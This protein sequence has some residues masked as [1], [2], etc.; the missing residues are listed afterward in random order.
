[1]VDTAVRRMSIGWTLLVQLCVV[2][3][4]SIIF[5][6]HIGADFPVAIIAPVCAVAYPLSELPLWSALRYPF[7][8]IVTCAGA[9]LLA[10]TSIAW[11]RFRSRLWA[12]VALALYSLLS[13]FVMLGFAI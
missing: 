3:V 7:V 11:F 10:G 8:V 12:H 9:A 6:T 4:V 5:F 13:M 1:M 2:E